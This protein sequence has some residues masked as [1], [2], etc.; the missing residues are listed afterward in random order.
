MTPPESD[1]STSS[2]ADL[3]LA[4]HDA[5]GFS[6]LRD[7][8]RA[9]IEAV[10]AGRNVLAVMPTGAGKSL[11]YQ[12]PAIVR[13]GLTVVVSPLVALMRDQV[14]ALRLN[15][16]AAATINSD[17]SREENV[18]TWYAVRDGDVRLLYLS[19]ERL[20]TDRMLAA[21]EKLDVDLFAIDEA[22]C[23]SQWGPAFRPEYAMLANLR[24]R[25]P[26]T[27]IIGL[28]ATADGATREDIEQRM[29]GGDVVNII[30]GFDRP[31]LSLGVTLKNNWKG[32]VAN[33]I[34]ERKGASGI[35][36][37]LSRRRQRRS[38][39]CCATRGT[40]PSPFMRVWIA[41]KKRTPK[42]DL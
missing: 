11:C 18:R 40:K 41:L 21:L 13:G 42:I 5:F 23:I 29:F 4:L 26:G 17:L 6:E 7:G 24:T 32:Q 36:Y 30:T 22:H 35:V 27:P 14:A 12:L 28:T 25:F 2:F 8:Q 15:D 31:D 33:F 16:I 34:E 3:G 1:F 19:P 20:M 38:R 10:M 37:C 39:L 9:A